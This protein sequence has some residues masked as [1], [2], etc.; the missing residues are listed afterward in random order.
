MGCCTRDYDTPPTIATPF[1]EAVKDFTFGGFT[2][3]KGWKWKWKWK[4]FRAINATNMNSE[5]FPNPE[6][7]DPSRFEGNG[8]APYTFVPFSVGPRTCPGKDCA[9][10]V[11]LTFI[12]NLVT[13]V[14]V[15][16]CI[17]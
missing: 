1:R 15:G 3:P 6:N 16:S 10:F 9:R 11:I 13:K 7:F 4:I 17:S 2:I 8:C 14:Q 12:H 5:Y